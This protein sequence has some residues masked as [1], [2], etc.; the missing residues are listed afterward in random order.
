MKIWG[1]NIGQRG[2]LKAMNGGSGEWIE[3]EE[4]NKREEGTSKRLVYVYRKDSNG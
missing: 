2:Y 1:G 4:I 3:D